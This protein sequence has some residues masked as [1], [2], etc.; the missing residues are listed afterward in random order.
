MTHAMTRDLLI[1]NHAATVAARRQA[2]LD[3]AAAAAADRQASLAAGAAE[4][5]ALAGMGAFSPAPTTAKVRTARGEGTS[6][7]TRYYNGLV[8]T[9]LA[10]GMTKMTVNGRSYQIKPRTANFTG[11]TGTNMV[12]ALEAALYH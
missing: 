4:V 9:A 12:A 1:R 7:M 3:A 2:S 6:K 10:S 5:A 8:E 11:A